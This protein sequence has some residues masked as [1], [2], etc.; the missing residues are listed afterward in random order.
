[1]NLK[2]QPAWPIPPLPIETGQRRLQVG[3]LLAGSAELDSR[4]HLIANVAVRSPIAVGANFTV[5][6][7][8]QPALRFDLQVEI[9]LKSPG[10][11]SQRNAVGGKATRVGAA[12]RPS[13]GYLP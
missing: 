13:V 9:S 2:L 4:A 8:S 3:F 7:Q 10:A 6:M 12:F 1:V 5:I 11:A